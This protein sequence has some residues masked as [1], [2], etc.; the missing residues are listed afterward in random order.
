MYR[1]NEVATGLPGE[2]GQG[3]W[4][5]IRRENVGLAFHFGLRVLVL[6]ALCTRIGPRWKVD[7]PFSRL[8]RSVACAL[9]RKPGPLTGNEFA[10]LR[11]HLAYSQRMLARW[12]QVS[13]TAIQKWENQGAQA[14]GMLFS[15]EILIRWALLRQLDLNASEILK[16][17]RNISSSAWDPRKEQVYV[18]DALEL[19][20]KRK[21]F[22]RAKHVSEICTLVGGI[23]TSVAGN[24][25]GRQ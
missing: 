23:R 9:V 1:Y 22:S 6:D 5:G 10:Y 17:M 4:F 21:S 20:G 7:L 11:W 18:F 24:W 25:L 12:F 8:E 19:S 3:K 13:H 14:T 2:E 15:R 16:I